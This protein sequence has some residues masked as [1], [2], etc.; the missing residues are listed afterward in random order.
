MSILDTIKG[1]FTK[2]KDDVVDPILSSE[3]QNEIAAM[4][5]GHYH[6]TVELLMRNLYQNG[7]MAGQVTLPKMQRLTELVLQHDRNLDVATD[8]TVYPGDAQRAQSAL[9]EE[10]QLRQEVLSES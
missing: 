3:T 10:S 1:I 5:L 4:A 2:S 8:V 6:E 9:F 7:L